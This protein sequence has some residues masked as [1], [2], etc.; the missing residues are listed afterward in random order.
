MS[1]HTSGPL[2]ALESD[3]CI[4]VAT[5]DDRDWVIAEMVVYST[6][7]PDLNDAVQMANATLYAA[8]PDYFDAVDRL[9]DCQNRDDFSGWNDAF[10]DLK[11]VHARVKGGIR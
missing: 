1:E 3:K 5:G 9:I 6:N 7:D 10:E 2:V 8:S 4:C 11:D